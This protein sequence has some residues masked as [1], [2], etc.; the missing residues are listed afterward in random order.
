MC[1]IKASLMDAK[2]N[3]KTERIQSQD[4][5][6][7]FLDLLSSLRSKVTPQAKPRAPIVGTSPGD[8]VD[9]K[10]ASLGSEWRDRM[11]Q[12]EFG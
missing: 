12:S 3:R 2:V 6:F 7:E 4:R 8:E 1:Q 10:A 5:I 9:D 11:N